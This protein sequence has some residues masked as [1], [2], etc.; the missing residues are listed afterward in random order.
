MITVNST[1]LIVI[2][3]DMVSDITLPKPKLKI[4][5]IPYK[6]V[7]ILLEKNKK[8]WDKKRFYKK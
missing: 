1:K 3:I 4:R 5:N 2:L 8:N 6:D 7:N